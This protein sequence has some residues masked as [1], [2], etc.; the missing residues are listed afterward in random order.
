MLIFIW[1]VV[2]VQVLALC[3]Y[4]VTNRPLTDI[5]EFCKIITKLLQ[6]NNR[7][8][9]IRIAASLSSESIYRKTL[10]PILNSSSSYRLEKNY[11]KAQILLDNNA[12]N[13]EFILYLVSDMMAALAFIIFGLFATSF[14]TLSIAAFILYVITRTISASISVKVSSDM[15]IFKTNLVDIKKLVEIMNDEG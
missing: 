10:I 7:D 3:F 14:S 9:A 15:Q 4:F 11:K 12:K 13:K 2:V 1:M 8:R 5:K 6:A